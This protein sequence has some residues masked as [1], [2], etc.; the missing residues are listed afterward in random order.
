MK[1]TDASKS[2]ANRTRSAFQ[3]SL[4]NC[5][6]IILVNPMARETNHSLLVY[7]YTTMMVVVALLWITIEV[8]L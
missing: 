1:N 7:T 8:L 2:I 6:S 5:L 4:E 3:T